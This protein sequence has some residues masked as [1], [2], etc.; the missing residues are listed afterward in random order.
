MLT[1]I[2][3]RSAVLAALL[4][5]LP[6][7]ALLGGAPQAGGGTATVPFRALTAEGQPVTDLKVGDVSLKIDGR[8]REIKSIEL[9]DE[10]RASAPAPEGKPAGEPPF[11]TNA[12][13]AAAAAGR[14]VYVL[15]DEESIAPGKDEAV[16]EA[17][18]HLVSA[19]SAE[20][21]VAMAS[22]RQGGP[23]VGLT[24]DFAGIKAAAGKLAGYAGGREESATDITCRTVKAIQT[25]QGV[26]QN[27]AALTEPP[28]VIFFSTS[29]ASLQAGRTVTVGGATGSQLCEIRTEQM[30][31]FGSAAQVARANFFVVELTDSGPSS[32]PAVASGGL[33]NLTGVTNGEM[34]RMSANAEAQMKRIAA[35]TSVYYL[36]AFE[37][38]ASDRSGTKRVDLTVARD[39]L[40][41][42][43]PRELA[44]GRPAGKSAS[45]SPR[46]MIRVATAFPDLPLRA[47]AYSSRNPGDDKVRVLALFE[48]M[49]PDT[50]LNAAVVGLFDEK[51]KL[52]AQWT[53]QSADLA[54]QPSMAALIVPAGTYRVR[55]AA[56]D[57]SGRSGAVDVHGFA[58]T[59]IEAGPIKLGDLVL[60]KIGPKGP[61]P[62]MQF[63][64]D[65]EAIAIIE[66]YGRPEGPLKMY[67]EVLTG[68][69]PVQIPLSPS[70]S[71]EPDKFLLS[72]QIPLASLKP[73]DY[74]VRAVVAVEGHPDAQ[75]TRTLR[76]VAAGS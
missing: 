37:A 56:K 33:E 12:S 69:E 21:R 62:A 26:F 13:M 34:L 42:K 35:S 53:A 19:L 63:E 22:I 68:G 32:F 74:T 47:A 57:A 75:V 71:N 67:A 66:L 49:D 72:A 16:K 24:T 11:A 73:G 29:L 60:G 20:D 64:G 51:G 6:A 61:V 18:G 38:E 31:Q 23:N 52:T 58:A 46:D 59:L 41:V 65:Q 5:V 45:A 55:I 4:S 54:T 25:L 43:A 9:I 2:C 15:V 40:T 36:A 28:T 39:G 30:N 14:D 1:S 76:K 27:A 50:K 44:F 48:P 17:I 3:R 70:A 8:A 10:R 7:A